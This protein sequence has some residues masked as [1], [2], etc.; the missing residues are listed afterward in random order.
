MNYQ[1]HKSV[2]ELHQQLLIG[3]KK[4]L[5]IAQTT[6]ESKTVRL[7]SLTNI[8]EVVEYVLQNMNE[9]IPVDEQA[10]YVRFFSLLLIKVK[11]AQFAIH[12]SPLTFV[13]EIGFIST[14]LKI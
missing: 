12:S 1:T 8:A 4:H 6:S 13:D 7:Q 9:A 10:I 11:H 3:I 2:K 14:L 5:M